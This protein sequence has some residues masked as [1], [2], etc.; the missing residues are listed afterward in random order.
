MNVTQAICVDS[1]RCSEI[2]TQVNLVKG[3]EKLQEKK[4]EGLQ[5]TKRQDLLRLGDGLHCTCRPNQQR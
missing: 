3:V 1:G 4:R 5:I 2:A